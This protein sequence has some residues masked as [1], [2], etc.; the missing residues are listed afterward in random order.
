MFMN[1]VESLF[2][3][4]PLPVFLL[5]NHGTSVAVLLLDAIFMED[6]DIDV[7]ILRRCGSRHS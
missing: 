1:N 4:V 6:L 5:E 2:H 7:F 3:Y